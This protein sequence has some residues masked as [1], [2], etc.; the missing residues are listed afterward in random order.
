MGVAIVQLVNAIFQLMVIFIIAS[1]I[2]SWL[3]AF[4]VLNIR[5]RFVGNVAYFLERVTYP[6]LEPFRRIIPTLGGIDISPIAALLALQFLQ[7]LFNRM[8]AP[9][10]QA[11]LG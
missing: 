1:A 10:L 4:D 2:L 6:V 11:T 5:N 9:G 3:V 7:T 8:L